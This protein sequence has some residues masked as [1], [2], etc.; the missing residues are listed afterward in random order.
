[1]DRLQAERL[2]NDDCM[3]LVVRSNS[4]EKLFY[5]LVKRGFMPETYYGN[6][7]VFIITLS[8]TPRGVKR[9]VRAIEKA[10]EEV[11]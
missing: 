9:L 3:R 6:Y 11:K 1:L 4:A 10:S 7:C 8:D 5:A 2:K